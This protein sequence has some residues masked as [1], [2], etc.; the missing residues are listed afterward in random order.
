MSERVSPEPDPTVHFKDDSEAIV[1]Q[2][3][4]GQERGITVASPGGIRVQMSN[5][6]LTDGWSIYRFG[7]MGIDECWEQN[8]DKRLHFTRINL[9][10]DWDCFVE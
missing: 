7:E 10:S 5:P 6:I 2:R 8:Q 9:T 3:W 1:Y 4:M